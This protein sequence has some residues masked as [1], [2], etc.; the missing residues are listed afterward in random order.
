MERSKRDRREKFQAKKFLKVPR[1]EKRQWRAA[2]RE[3]REEHDRR[4]RIQ[5]QDDRRID[6]SE[7]KIVDVR[8]SLD[9][10]ADPIIITHET[11]GRH[12][13]PLIWEDEP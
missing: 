2:A 5:R 8:S 6:I 9:Q 1:V 10:I 4:S 12:R 3:I 13:E 11:E 7:Q